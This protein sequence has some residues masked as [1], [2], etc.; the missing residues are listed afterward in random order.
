MIEEP[1][2]DVSSLF[3]Q[4]LLIFLEDSPQSNKYHQVVFTQPQF[5]AMSDTMA[6]VF[7]GKPDGDEMEEI[8]I[9]MSMTTH[10]LPDLQSYYV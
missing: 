5:K 1:T 9:N 2:I 4:R 7:G 6:I 10:T 8:N 3:E